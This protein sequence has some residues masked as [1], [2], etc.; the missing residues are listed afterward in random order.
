MTNSSG[1]VFRQVRYTAYG[2]IRGRYDA[3]SGTLPATES[4]RQEFTNYETEPETGLQYAHARYYD[5]TLTQFLSHDP[6]GQFASGYQYTAFD[7]VNASD[8]TGKFIIESVIGA[9]VWS[10]FVLGVPTAVA[11]ATSRGG[12]WGQA[13]AG[14]AI[15]IISAAATAY[16][17]PILTDKLFL[18]SHGTLTFRQAQAMVGIGFATVS[19]GAS[20]ARGDLGGILLGA[21]TVAALAYG[22][23]PASGAAAASGNASGSSKLADDTGAGETGE[24]KPKLPSGITYSDTPAPQG[25]APTSETIEAARKELD[26]LSKYTTMSRKEIGV[27]AKGND[28]WYSH[29]P[30][31]PAGEAGSVKL[32]RQY[33]ADWEGHTHLY[34]GTPSGQDLVSFA[35]AAPK[36]G[37]SVYHHFVADSGSNSWSVMTYDH[38]KNHIYWQDLGHLR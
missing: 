15:G 6:A 19:T 37:A 34:D 13:L 7:P 14:L 12:S 26:P 32:N 17:A 35:N 9:A 30:Y 25:V 8:P 38:G 10:A 31:T 18:A 4:K 5:P 27:V 29:G 24:L 16:I 20:A 21:A 1:A 22:L 2:D 3:G 33:G 23:F 11:I 28:R 36:Y